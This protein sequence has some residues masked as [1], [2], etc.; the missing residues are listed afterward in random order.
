MSDTSEMILSD[1][2]ETANF[3][4]LPGELSHADQIKRLIRVN[5]AGEF[6][7]A[8][9]Y[10]GQLSVLRGTEIEPTLQRMYQ[11]ELRKLAS[12]EELINQRGVRPTI[13]SPVWQRAGF[14]LGALTA[15]MGKRAAM[16]CTAAVE[17]V[18]DHQYAEQLE[19]LRPED[20][21]L[22]DVIERRQQEE[23]GE[24]EATALKMDAEHSPIY[25]FLSHVVKAGSRLTTFLSKRF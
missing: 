22:S 19:R 18:I 11:Q 12:L 25:P 17:Q 14:A 20:Q 13:L 23:E 6:G 10:R 2:A 1:S 16:A 24:H 15:I 21:D 5:H 7:A 9:I 3:R 4:D 8:Q